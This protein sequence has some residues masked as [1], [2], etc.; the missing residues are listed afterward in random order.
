MQGDQALRKTRICRIHKTV[1]RRNKESEDRAGVG[2]ASLFNLKLK[3]KAQ[4]QRS[5][6]GLASRKFE[7][8][9]RWGLNA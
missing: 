6:H 2:K 3:N 5:T 8:E 9:D 1:G 7:L 4:S